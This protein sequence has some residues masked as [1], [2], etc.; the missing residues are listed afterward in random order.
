[1]ELKEQGRY[2]KPD[3]EEFGKCEV[4]GR[5]IAIGLARCMHCKGSSRLNRKEQPGQGRALG[6]GGLLLIL[7]LVALG[8]WGYRRLTERKQ[9][10]SAAQAGAPV[11][12]QV[13]DGNGGDRARGRPSTPVQRE[14]DTS[15]PRV[16]RSAEPRRVPT[17]TPKQT[18]VRSAPRLTTETIVCPACAGNGR[19]PCPAPQTGTY[20]CP[21]C[22][23]A[24]NR[25][26]R[27]LADQWKLCSTCKGMGALARED[28]LFRT[29]NRI[30]K[31]TCPTCAG[32]GLVA[33]E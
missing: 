11:T 18:S 27:F 4:C 33:V 21:V 5:P 16:Q 2:G 20:T 19:L 1:M 24:G 26:R 23:G 29:K 8:A 7:L 32:K 6:L 14:R 17:P 31:E 13:D 30:V 25:T 12:G 10:A 22:T 3:S 28:D 9:R 15:A